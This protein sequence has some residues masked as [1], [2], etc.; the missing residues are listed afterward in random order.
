MTRVEGRDPLVRADEIAVHLDAVLRPEARARHL[1]VAR[2]T[3]CIMTARYVEVP[4]AVEIRASPPPDDFAPWDHV[5]EAS[6]DVPSGCIAVHGP[7]DYFPEAPRIPIEPGTYRARMYFGGIC[8]VSVDG[9][10]GEDHYRV[11]LWPAPTEAPKVLYT[12]GSGEW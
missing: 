10:D 12:Q 6:L 8:T 2:G 1:G 4:V 5:V 9:L 3:L 11:A 7:T